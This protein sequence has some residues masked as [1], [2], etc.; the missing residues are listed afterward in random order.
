MLHILSVKAM[1]LSTPT[2]TTKTTHA[3]STLWPRPIYSATQHRFSDQSMISPNLLRPI[4][5]IRTTSLGLLT[6]TTCRIAMMI[7]VKNGAVTTVTVAMTTVRKA[8]GLGNFVNADQITPYAID[9]TF[10]LKLSHALIFF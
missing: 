7:V 1:D 4:T 10:C 6:S 2:T 5:N 8:R 3:S 9:Q